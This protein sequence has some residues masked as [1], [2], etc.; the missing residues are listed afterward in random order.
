MQRYGAVVGIRPERI[1]EY[2]ELHAAV[3]PEVL[4]MIAA[5]NI[6]NYSIFLRTLDDGRPYLFSYFEYVGVDFAADMAKM[7]TDPDTQRWWAVTKPCHQPLADRG[8]DEW[9]ASME[10]VFH[11]D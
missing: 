10:E 7:A 8:E 1:Q 11:V 9:W 4:K 2:K 3:W 6:R 5:C